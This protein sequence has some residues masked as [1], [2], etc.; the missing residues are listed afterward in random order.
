[1]GSQNRTSSHVISEGFRAL[2]PNKPLQL[3]LA[4]SSSYTL[5]AS[6]IESLASSHEASLITYLCY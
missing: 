3:E 2:D 6:Q 4:L 5:H 1:M